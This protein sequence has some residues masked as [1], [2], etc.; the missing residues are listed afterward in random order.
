M[1]R[2]V[3]MHRPAY[4]IKWLTYNTAKNLDSYFLQHRK[5]AFWYSRFLEG[6]HDH[7]DLDQMDEDRVAEKLVHMIEASSS[8]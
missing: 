7:L 8:W 2:F 4:D 5:N 1:R 3:Q 6:P